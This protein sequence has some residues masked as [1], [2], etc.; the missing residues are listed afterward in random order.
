MLK[1]GPLVCNHSLHQKSPGGH[2][3]CKPSEI[4]QIDDDNRVELAREVDICV[5]EEETRRTI[6]HHVSQPGLLYFHAVGGE[7]EVEVLDVAKSANHVS[8]SKGKVIS[9]DVSVE[10]DHLQA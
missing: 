9:C 4:G 7:E 2:Q 10:E 1:E 6:L 3:C 5:E 8:E